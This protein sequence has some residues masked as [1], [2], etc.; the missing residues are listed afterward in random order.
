MAKYKVTAK[1]GLRA[2]FNPRMDAPILGVATEGALIDVAHIDGEWAAVPLVAGGVT[3]KPSAIAVDSGF[4]YLRVRAGGSLYL[5]PVLTPLP[6]APA[7]P[8]S[9][10]SPFWLAAC[11]SRAETV[12]PCRTLVL[13]DYLHIGGVLDRTSFFD[14]VRQTAMLLGLTVSRHRGHPWQKHRFHH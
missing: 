8:A 11:R 13:S 5:A 12:Y 2:R 4:C 7:A 14:T 6:A 9:P 3:L 1:G 10:A